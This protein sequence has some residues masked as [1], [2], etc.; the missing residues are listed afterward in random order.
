[1]IATV[2]ASQR[3][4]TNAAARRLMVVGEI[5][6]AVY[7]MT[8]FFGLQVMLASGSFALGLPW[9]TFQPPYWRT[10]LIYG[11]GAAYIA[12]LCWRRSPRT[13]F[14]AYVFLTVD[15]IRAMR[16][17]HWEMV[18]IDLVVLSA[19]QLPMFRAVYPSIH[20][21]NLRGRRSAPQAMSVNGHLS[22]HGGEQPMNGRGRAMHT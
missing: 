20:P 10:L 13:R 12:Y 22:P 18:L 21:G 14:A 8:A 9:L 2:I 3:L 11:G 19:M 7:I 17:S 16:G 15:L 5:T 6:P 1:M 4:A